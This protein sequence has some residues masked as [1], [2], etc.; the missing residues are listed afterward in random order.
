M[1]F[2]YEQTGST[3]LI[4]LDIL[5]ESDLVRLEALRV[6]CGICNAAGRGSEGAGGSGDAGV[7]VHEVR[8]KLTTLLDT[9]DG[10]DATKPLHLQ[11]VCR[12]HS[13]PYDN[14]LSWFLVTNKCSQII[15]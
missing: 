11:M 3:S 1:Y 4:S 12:Q 9:Q 14:V 5:S 15:M 6:L 10:W 13:S 2:Q 8:K 7:H